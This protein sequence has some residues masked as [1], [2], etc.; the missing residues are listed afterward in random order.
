MM[1]MVFCGM[2]LAKKLAVLITQPGPFASLV[3]K[4]KQS[5]ASDNILGSK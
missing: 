5:T 3:L 4:Q 2:R 1:A